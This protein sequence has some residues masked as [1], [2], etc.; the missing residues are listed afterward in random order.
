[1]LD[2]VSD[3]YIKVSNL[4]KWRRREVCAAVTVI[5]FAE[6]PVKHS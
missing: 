5:I 4:E 2:W 3:Y 1:M 6:D